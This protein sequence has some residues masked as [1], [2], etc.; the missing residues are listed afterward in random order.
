MENIN[1]LENLSTR[2][3]QSATVKNV[4]GEPVIAGDKTIIPVAQIIYGFGGGYGYGQK[5][6]NF[7]K[8]ESVPGETADEK[9]KIGE[10]LGGGGGVIAKPKGVYEISKSATR[11]IPA[12]NSMQILAAIIFGMVIKSLLLKRHR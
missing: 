8:Q 11:F 9:K 2:L 10:G 7:L 6:K 4:Y 12:N 3:G 1:F 5:P